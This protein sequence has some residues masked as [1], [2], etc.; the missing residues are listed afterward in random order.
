[1][2]EIAEVAPETSSQDAPQTHTIASGRTLLDYLKADGGW[3]QFCKR[4]PQEE[5]PVYKLVTKEN[6]I[7]R[8]MAGQTEEKILG[9]LQRRAWM[10]AQE[11]SE[12]ICYGWEPEMWA[13]ADEWWDKGRELLILGGNRCLAGEQEIY[14]PVA[15]V[16]RRVDSIEGPFH[17]Q[18]W[19]GTGIVNAEASIPFKK[20]QA[21]LYKVTLAD[22]QSWS[23]SREHLV[24]GAHG[25]YTPVSGLV[26]GTLLFVPSNVD[27]E[28]GMIKSIEYLRDDTVW[29]FE[30]PTFN[31]YFICNSLHHNSGKTTF[32]ARRVVQKLMAKPW[33]IVWCFSTSFETSV[34]DQQR[35]IWHYLPSIWR[36]ARRNRITN[37]SYT[38]KGGFTQ[39]MFVTPQGA[40][41]RFMNYQQDADVIEGGQ[42]DLWWADELIPADWVVT[43]RSRVVDR[44][45]R[46][47][48]TQTPI[49]GYTQTVAEY[50]NGAQVIE[51]ADA[52]LL[53][54]QA[55]WPGG[56]KGKVP[57]KVQC[58]N[59][60]QRVFFFHSVHNPYVP[61]EELVNAWKDKGSANIL[62]RLYGVTS[63]I[64]NCKFPRFGAHNI[65]KHENI[66]ETGTNYQVIDFSWNKPWAMVW[67]RVHQVGDKKFIYIYRE[68]PDMDSHGE[69]V[70]R[71]EKPDGAPG[72][73]QQSCG[74]GINDYKRLIF[75]LEAKGS[76][77]EQRKEVKPEPVFS[78]YGDP[79]SGAATALADE[80]ATTIFQMLEREDDQIGPLIVEPVVGTEGNHHILEGVNLINTWLEYDADKPFSPLNCPQLY[81]SDKCQNTIDCLKMWTGAQGDKGASKDF[82]DLLRYLAMTAPE[83][84]SAIQP[85]LYEGG[86]Y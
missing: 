55:H 59:P 65:L 14:D 66:P 83:D 62:C 75:D 77:H 53:P 42:V 19:D 6:I 33:S 9:M 49:R 1:M 16:S 79:R 70:V 81:I 31:A 67:A 21:P 48:I 82:V 38:Q 69:W 37:L 28:A 13:K 46:G 68:W 5:H 78:R 85:V 73:A 24:L 20:P 51:W 41:C 17:V 50:L 7:A 54:T 64:S 12:P 58:M 30:V 27:R 44:R 39:K 63:G 2:P 74:F 3:E 43:M 34:R 61:Y 18:S 4:M 23:A 40:E 36:V 84:M 32:A 22:G 45:G 60:Q 8:L 10:I 35:A 47:L 25:K 56:K 71:S 52:P 86:S 72:P 11:R 76:P 57:L 29:D 15:N 26:P 80:G